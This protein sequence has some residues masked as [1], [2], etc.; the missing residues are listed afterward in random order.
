MKIDRSDYK[1]GVQ[2]K[3]PEKPFGDTCVK[4]YANV[5]TGEKN[6]SKEKIAEFLDTINANWNWNIDDYKE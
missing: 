2:W 1:V 6:L 3:A 5:L 4:S